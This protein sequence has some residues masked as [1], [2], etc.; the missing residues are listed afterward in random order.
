MS[1]SIGIV[2][3]PNVGKSTLFNALLKR[4][5]ALAANYPFATI[6][7][8]V[9]IVDVP[10]ERL[11]ELSKIVKKEYGER[12]G[13]RVVPEKIVP[14]VVKFVD[15][16]GLVKGA[17]KGEGLGNKFLAHIR[18]V[19]AIVHVLRD[20]E[21]PNI[22]REGS[23]DPISDFEVIRTELMLADLASVEKKLDSIKRDSKNPN[24]K[25]AVAQFNALNK[26]L[27]ILNTQD[28][29]YESLLDFTEEEQR[30]I[31]E[32]SLLT[33][34]PYLKVYNISEDKIGSKSDSSDDSSIFLCAKIESEIS[35]LSEQDQK[36]FMQELKISESGLDQVIK[37]GYKLLG[38]QTFLTA[39]PK[40]VR[41]W[42]IRKGFKAPQAAGVIHT[43]FER[44]FISA[45]VV[46]YND[47]ISCQGWKAAKERGLLRIE[48]KEYEMKDGD[49]VEFRFNV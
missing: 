45:E 22:V 17:S 49:V 30:A 47:L 43:D 24:N 26:V 19:D 25:A 5:V 31:K 3:L 11:L 20:F 12:I 7:P 32:L 6:E 9:G 40:E 1:L 42:T 44:G 10:D 37:A 15:I 23:V 21:D 35:S 14:A 38:L 46:G 8:N 28:A 39:G 33:A 48:G 29:L 2:G 27:E 13:D 4:Q 18:E 41:A 36:L 16:A 34:K